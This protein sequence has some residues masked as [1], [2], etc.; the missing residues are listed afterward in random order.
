LSEY[1]EMSECVLCGRSAGEAT[2]LFELNSDQKLLRCGCG[3]IYNDRHRADIEQIYD[4]N[5]YEG[6]E[7]GRVGGYYSY[8][9][10]ERATNKTDRFASSFIRNRSKGRDGKIRLL[11]VGCGYGFFLKQFKGEPEMEL[12]GIEAS[13]AAAKKA[14]EVTDNIIHGCFEDVDFRGKSDFA[15]VSAFEVIEHLAD[16]PAF[17][18]KVNRILEDGGYFFMST[19]DIGSL[20]FK[21]LKRRWP[22]IHPNYHNVYF[23]KMTLRT[24]A[25]KCGFEIVRMRSKNFYYTNVRHVRK[26]LSELFPVVGRLFAILKP[27]DVITVPF[28]NGGDLQV[29]LRKKT[30]PES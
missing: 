29:I 7:A 4:S 14:A 10:M 20:W 21:A 24:V 19:P 26:R 1:V 15:F 11:D 12:A 9:Q 22:G 17:L 13:T 27:F 18:R 8:S 28:L 30:L 6:S 16:P 3:L 25:E 2:V 5:Y 23:S